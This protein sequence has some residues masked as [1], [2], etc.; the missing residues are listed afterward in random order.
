VRHQCPH[1]KQLTPIWKQLAE[2]WNNEDGDENGDGVLVAQVNCDDINSLSAG[3]HNSLCL[4]HGVKVPFIKYGDPADLGSRTGLKLYDK[5]RTF[6]QL[7][8]L[9]K[10]ELLGINSDVEKYDTKAAA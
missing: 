7:D 9:I 10:V 8:N 5:D 1:C 2:S 4:R 6:E 3:P